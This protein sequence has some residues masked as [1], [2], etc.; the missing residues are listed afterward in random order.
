MIF[1]NRKGTAICNSVSEVIWR[2]FFESLNGYHKHNI[3]PP[4][5]VSISFRLV[6]SIVQWRIRRPTAS[7]R[8]CWDFKQQGFSTRKT[9]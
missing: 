9:R 3:L 7:N 8:S 6:S 1:P 4:A 2:E 5:R